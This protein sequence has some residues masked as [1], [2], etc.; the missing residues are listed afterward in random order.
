MVDADSRSIDRLCIVCSPD[1]S[2]ASFGSGLFKQ[3]EATIINEWLFI[4][5]HVEY[6]LNWRKSLSDISSTVRMR[7]RL[8]NKSEIRHAFYH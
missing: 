2:K 7:M 1:I 4:I 8:R 3:F 6:A 5:Q